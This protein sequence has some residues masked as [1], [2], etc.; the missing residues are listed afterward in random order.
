VLSR[1]FRWPA[2]TPQMNVGHFAR[3]EAIERRLAGLPGLF[4]TGAG[5]RATGIPDTVGDARRTA[6]AAVD[7]TRGTNIPSGTYRPADDPA[8][9]P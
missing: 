8:T 6:G 3:V 7:W 4:V 1:V 5:L 2:G 9:R